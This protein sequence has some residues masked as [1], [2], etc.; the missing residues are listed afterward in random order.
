MTGTSV[1]L[2]IDLLSEAIE[3]EALLRLTFSRPTDADLPLKVTSS[4]YRSKDGEVMVGTESILPDG[5]CIRKNRT[6]NEM[7]PKS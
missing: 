5:K 3:K 2:F 7:H 6:K 1:S 4:L